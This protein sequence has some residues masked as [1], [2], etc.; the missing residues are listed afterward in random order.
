MRKKYKVMQEDHN[1]IRSQENVRFSLQKLFLKI[2]A[3]TLLIIVY[4]NL[5]M[6]QRSWLKHY[7]TS[8]NVA[9]SSPDEVEFFQLT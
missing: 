2:L 9:V 3:N 7:T 4:Y 5:G 6:E 1:L 8:R